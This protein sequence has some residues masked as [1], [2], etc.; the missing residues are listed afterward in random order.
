MRRPVYKNPSVEL[1]TWMCES[2][3][4]CD[5]QCNYRISTCSFYMYEIPE[6]HDAQRKVCACKWR[7]SF[8][9]C[10]ITSIIYNNVVA[11]QCAEED[12]WSYDRPNT[13][14]LFCGRNVLRF[15][16]TTV[17]NLVL[18]YW[19]HVCKY[20]ITTSL[21][22]V[23]WLHHSCV[24][25]KWDMC[26]QKWTWRSTL[27]ATDALADTDCRALCGVR[28]LV[29]EKRKTFLLGPSSPIVDLAD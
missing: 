13:V 12:I 2:I 22:C 16:I 10:T 21:S 19:Y 28:Q 4:S 25:V 5:Y 3:Q 26:L 7:L 24:I 11:V 9:E 29:C 8:S 20:V 27:V 17:G 1:F 6:R 18:L 23:R 15:S 14:W